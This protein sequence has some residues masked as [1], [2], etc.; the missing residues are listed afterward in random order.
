[1]TT[2]TT[3]PQAP[4]LPIHTARQGHGKSFSGLQIALENVR[5]AITESTLFR[6]INQRLAKEGQALRKTQFKSRW[7]NDLGRFYIVDLHTNAPVA[8]HQDLEALGRELGV[9]KATE[10]LQEE[11]GEA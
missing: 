5:R 3:T 9:L 2:G 6:R 7:F 4:G 11:G 1:M 8:Q 10:R